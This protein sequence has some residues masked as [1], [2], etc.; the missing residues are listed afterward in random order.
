MSVYVAVSTPTPGQQI[1]TTA[2]FDVTFSASTDSPGGVL[3]GTQVII[4]D[5]NKSGAQVYNSGFVAASGTSLT[6]TQTIPANTL[7]AGKTYVIQTYVVDNT[8]QS[9]IVDVTVSAVGATVAP[10]ITVP[11]AAAVIST[12]MSTVTWTLANGNTNYQ[13]QVLNGSTVVFDTGEVASTAQTNTSIPFPDTGVSRT[14]RVRAKRGPSYAWSPWSTVNVTVAH[15]PPMTPTI[16][17][18]TATDVAGIGYAHALVAAITQPTPSG[19]A[20]AVVSTEFYVRAVGDPGNGALV[21]TSPT[22]ATSYTFKSPTSG[23]SYQMR[24]RVVSADNRYAY[25]AWVTAN[26]AL[27]LRGVVLYS[28]AAPTVVKLFRYNGDE[29]QDDYSAEAELIQYDGRPLPVVEFGTAGS[30]E[31]KVSIAVKTDVDRDAL[32]T[33]LLSRSIVLYR[34]RRGRKLYALI[35]SGPFVDTI[36]GTST[37]LTVTA[38]DYPLDRSV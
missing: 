7:T 34:D 23:V 16:T 38:L 30:R 2:T 21:D 8:A 14:V 12:P 6:R 26:A 29:A 22:S 1:G 20:P 31:L 9:A 5:T 35:T 32:R 10:T 11:A 18:L 13:I 15:T 4:F 37:E 24:V 17:S 33:M 25:S 27:A 19:G 28:L 36:Y 3:N